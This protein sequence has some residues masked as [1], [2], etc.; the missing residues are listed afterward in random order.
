MAVTIKD[1]ARAAGVSVATVTRA[2]SMPDVVRAATRERVLE[3]AKTLGYQPNRA[4]RGLITGRTGN[5]G[6]LVPDLANPFFPGIVK[7]VQARAHEADH[8]VFLA[9]TDENPAAEAGLVRKLAKQVDGVVLCSPRMPEAELRA[10]AADIPIVLVYRR[11]PGTPSVTAAFL[12]G[13]RQAISHL[14]ALG[15]QRI[16]YVAGPRSSWANRERVKSLRAVGR[17][18]AGNGSP[19]GRASAEGK[20]SA[21]AKCE[22]VEMGSV[23]PTFEG[24]VAAADGVLAAGVTAVIAYNDLVALGLLHRC[25]ARGVRVPGDLSVLGFDDIPL[26]AMVHPAL[27]TVA[28]P[29]GPAGRAAV[30][31]LLQERKEKREL[32]TQL[33]VRGS[34]G[35]AEG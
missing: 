25:A 10:L 35:P 28:L 22:L 29:K 5:L 14:T 2:L 16:A 24:G 27:T 19:A 3:T 13:M 20:V 1:V 21:A 26:G 32:P 31:L 30:D 15:H 33:I 18:V 11:I 8:A 23:T 12:D 7:G 4:A 9:D 34:T 6:L 17:D